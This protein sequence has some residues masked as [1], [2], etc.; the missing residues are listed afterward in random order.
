MGAR[1]VPAREFTGD[2][3]YLLIG[4]ILEQF[5][6]LVKRLIQAQFWT[7]TARIQDF[8]DFP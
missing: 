5:F 1:T 4:L 2:E 8:L 6:S 7:L 3:L